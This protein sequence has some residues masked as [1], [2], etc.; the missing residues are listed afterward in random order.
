[1]LTKRS[2]FRMYVKAGC[3]HCDKAKEIIQKD[4]KS[5]LYLVDVTDRPDVRESIIRGTGHRT[6]PAIYIGEEFI[7]GCDDLVNLVKTGDIKMKL[8]VEEN[9]ILKEEIKRLRRSL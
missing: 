5:S 9:N 2:V 8:L 4:L 7:G 3:P 1:M 6:V